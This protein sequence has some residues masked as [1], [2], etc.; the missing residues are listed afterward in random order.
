MKKL[1][2]GFLFLLL[3]AGLSATPDRAVWVSESLVGFRN[4]TYIIRQFIS[5]NMG[6]HYNQH[7]QVFL[8]VKDLKTNKVLSRHVIAD[9]SYQDGKAVKGKPEEKLAELMTSIPELFYDISYALPD[10]IPESPSEKFELK[11]NTIFISSPREKTELSFPLKDYIAQ[12]SIQ[13][14][15][16]A[17][18]QTY[19]W[20]DYI[21]FLVDFSKAYSDM[22]Y[23]QRIISLRVSKDFE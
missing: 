22:N 17:I 19:Y 23:N 1:S 21:L 5:D 12:E 18:L 15:A 11:N 4:D 6:S 7:L 20:K 3:A 14:P 9:I 16:H 10:G 8:V 2:T 13:D